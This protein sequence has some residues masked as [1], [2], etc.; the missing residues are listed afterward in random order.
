MKCRPEEC[1]HCIWD[2]VKDLYVCDKEF[3]E[4]NEYEDCIAEEGE[5]YGV[6]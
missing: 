3:I 1:E 2:R 5:D 6:I 4:T